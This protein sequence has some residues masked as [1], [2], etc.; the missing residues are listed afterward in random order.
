METEGRYIYC[1]MG[2]DLLPGG[3]GPIG[4]GDRGDLVYTVL[5][6]DIGAAISSTPMRRYAVTREYSLAH[7]KVI[8]EVMRQNDVLPV[9][10]CTIAESEE[11]VK[12]ILE[13]EYENFKA[14]LIG[15]RDKMEL[16]LKAVLN[17]DVYQDIAAG[18]DEVKAFKEKISGMSREAAF[19][20]RVKA[21]QVVQDSLERL[22]ERYKADILDAL[23]PLSREVRINRNIGDMMAV[24]AAFLVDKSMETEFDERVA[25]LDEEHGERLRLK[26]AC[27]LPPYN[28]VNISI[29]IGE[30]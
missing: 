30:Y 10:Y 12:R 13:K 4:M 27:G 29:N 5:H 19:S 6:K 2:G 9:R 16:G 25:R 14:S 23:S 7:M 26:Y 22:K 15:I 17:K 3:F 11:Q 20:L 28:F 21:G 1:I 8:A 24:N 18:S